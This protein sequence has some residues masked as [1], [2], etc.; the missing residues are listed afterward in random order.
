MEVLKFLFA[1]FLS[2]LPGFLG[3]MVVPMS[4]GENFWYS[5][6]LA[7]ELTPAA[8]VFSAVWTLL[9]FLMGVALY[10]I[11]RTKN[12]TNR[13]KPVN[14]YMWFTIN[15]IFNVLWSFMFFGMHSPAFA[16]AVLFALIIISIF[17][18]RAFMRVNNAAG[19]LTV[20]YV[21]WL[22]FAFYL[23]AMIVYLN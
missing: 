16:L 13:A 7:S 4:E 3:V 15:V 11:M 5:N 22:M 12:S 18:A 9:Y 14:A 10:L 20:P 19:W 21:I 2:F 8:W 23:N 17:M 6:L 1:I